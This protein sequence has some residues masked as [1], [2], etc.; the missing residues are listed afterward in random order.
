MINSVK[1]GVNNNIL[2]HKGELDNRRNVSFS[3]LRDIFLRSCKKDEKN[4]SKNSVENRIKMLDKT[5]KTFE[6]E[7]YVDDKPMKLK[8]YKKS[9]YGSNPGMYAVDDKNNLYYTKQADEQSKVEVFASKLYQLAGIETPEMSLYRDKD[10]EVGL[11]SKYVEHQGAINNFSDKGAK[12]SVNKGFVADAWL[13]NWDGV[14]SDNTLET[15]EGAVRIDFGGCLD[16]RAR[17]GKKNNFGEEVAELNTLIDPDINWQAASIYET[18]TRDGLIDSFLKVVSIKNEDIEKL[19]KESDMEQYT[20]ILI[21]RKDYLKNVFK[22]VIHSPQNSFED[23][24]TYMK[25]VTE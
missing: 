16:F 13:A 4:V 14:L 1:Y 12:K 25:R 15:Q 20:D 21:S 19:A 17:G 3:S 11:I 7:V 18:M 9:Q 24:Q 2:C 6:E 22:N 23:M 10:G 8:F 5:Y